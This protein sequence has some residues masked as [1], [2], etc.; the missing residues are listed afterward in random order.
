MASIVQRTSFRLGTGTSISGAFASNL[1]SGNIIVVTVGGNNNAA[2]VTP[3]SVAD[4]QS[5]TYTQAAAVNETGAGQKGD[6][7]AVF[8]ATAKSG[9]D[10]VSATASAA[11]NPAFL[12][13]YELSNVTTADLVVS[14]GTNTGASGSVA[15]FTAYTNGIAIAMASNLSDSTLTAGTNYTLLNGGSNQTDSQFSTTIAGANTAPIFFSVS[16]HNGE[17]LADFKSTAVAIFLQ[18]GPK[19][20]YRREGF[21]R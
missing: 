15:S 10:T 8:Y 13:I 3:V 12:G 18:S 20:Q 9:A 11:L 16:G 1:A 5:N 19:R 17:A 14:S 7:E 21:R 6:Y 2:D 4:S